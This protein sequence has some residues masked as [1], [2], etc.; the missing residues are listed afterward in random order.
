MEVSRN[1][2]SGSKNEFRA[3]ALQ[4]SDERA[5]IF[6]I[7]LGRDILM[8]AIFRCGVDALGIEVRVLR[9]TLAEIVTAKIE[10]EDVPTFFTEPAFK[11]A[12]ADFG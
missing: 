6:G 8:A 3:G 2:R 12:K 4:A 1:G 9:P 10:M 5:E 11:I 7:S